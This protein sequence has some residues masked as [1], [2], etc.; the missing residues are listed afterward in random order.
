[1]ITIETDRVLVL[2]RRGDP[3]LARCAACAREVEM[4]TPDEAA[5]LARANT[6]AIY[7]W[8]EIGR[9]HFTE[10]TDGRTFICLSSL[11]GRAE[12]SD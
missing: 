7:R 8:M 9:V 10:T 2:R 11:Q 12:Q 4:L 3:I 6:H 1:M 5:L